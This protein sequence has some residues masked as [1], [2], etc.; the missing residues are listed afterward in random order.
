M[1]GDPESLEYE[2]LLTPEGRASLPLS[3]LLLLYLDP[4]A[5]FMDASRGPAG[6]RERAL[7]YNRE[8]RSMLLT[9][10]RRWLIIA[11]GSFLGIASAEALAAHGP[12]FI[13][14]IVGFGIGCSI[15]LTV[16]ACTSAAYLL[17]GIRR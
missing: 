10:I 3:R 12:L 8:R 11:G 5:L 15:A 14:P 7:S 16:A 17:L 2:L 9:Y 13:I 4:F 1:T 6:R